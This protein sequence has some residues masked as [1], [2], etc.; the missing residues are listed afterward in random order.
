MFGLDARIALAVFGALSVIS[1]AALYS[2]IGNAKATAFLYDI[3][4]IGKAWEQYYLDTG[5]DLNL[6]GPTGTD[7]NSKQTSNLVVDPGVTGWK[8]PYLP[9]SV[10]ATEPRVITYNNDDAIYWV[11]ADTSDW[12]HWT[13]GGECS[14]P[15]DCYRWVTIYYLDDSYIPIISKIDEMIDNGDG[16]SKGDFRFRNVSTDVNYI[17]FKYAPLQI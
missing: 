16:G 1:G 14:S 6:Y 12:N 8:G 17:F 11:H 5:Q 15:P 9:Y 7:A 10:F 3:K 2:A 4:E 13:V